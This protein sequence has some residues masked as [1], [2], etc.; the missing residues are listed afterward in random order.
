[1]CVATT[2]DAIKLLKYEPSNWKLGVKIKTNPWSHL[3]SLWVTQAGAWGGL[4]DQ[5]RCSPSGYT[6]LPRPHPSLPPCR[7]HDNKDCSLRLK[8]QGR[9]NPLIVSPSLFRS[10]VYF[11]SLHLSVCLFPSLDSHGGGKVGHNPKKI[12]ALHKLLTPR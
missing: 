8:H 6:Y 11:H 7:Y 12:R 2:Y 10:L 1:M 4:T 3:L 9:S 5:W